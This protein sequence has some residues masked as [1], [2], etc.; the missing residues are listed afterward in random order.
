MQF[1][2]SNTLT[3]DNNQ[4]DKKHF[5][6]DFFRLFCVVNCSEPLDGAAPAQTYSS[7]QI[8]FSSLKVFAQ[9]MLLLLKPATLWNIYSCPLGCGCAGQQEQQTEIKHD[10]L[11]SSDLG[12]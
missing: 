10:F 12:F 7:I 3:V 9:Q 8:T 2:N 6:K 4:V 5:I 1:T 11:F